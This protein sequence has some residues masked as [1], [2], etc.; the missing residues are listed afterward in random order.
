MSIAS[1]YGWTILSRALSQLAPRQ[2]P[3]TFARAPAPHLAPR[4]A[5]KSVDVVTSTPKVN[6][7][8][9]RSIF[10]V[11]GKEYAEIHPTPQTLSTM[12]YI[13]AKLPLRLPDPV[14]SDTSIFEDS[15]S[16]IC[17][18]EYV[19]VSMRV[20]LRKPP[21]S[22]SQTLL[23]LIRRE[24]YEEA[25]PLCQELLN[26]DIEIPKSN[27]YGYAVLAVLSSKKLSEEEKVRRCEV[28]LNLIPSARDPE[29]GDT[30]FKWLRRGV[31]QFLQPTMTFV[32]EFS[33][34]MASK[35]YAEYICPDAMI[36]ITRF[37]STRVALR[38]VKDILDCDLSYAVDEHPEGGG[39]LQE[40]HEKKRLRRLRELAHRVQRPA[41]ETFARSGK[42]H[43][44]MSL[45]PTPRDPFRLG[46]GTYDLLLSLLRFAPRSY[47]G[48]I[49]RVEKLRM[50]P[51]Y[52]I[53]TPR[54]PSNDRT[55]MPGK[56]ILLEEELDPQS[57]FYMGEALAVQ[58]QS[59]LD[60][61]RISKPSVPELV[62]F[63]S[64]YLESGRT[65]AICRLRHYVLK[66]NWPLGGI[67]LYAEMSYYLDQELY[68]LVLQ[69]FANYFYFSGIPEKEVFAAIS[70]LDKSGHPAYL[71]KPSVTSRRWIPTESHS[72][73][74]WH[75]LARSALPGHG[76]GRLY[77]RFIEYQTGIRDDNIPENAT[78]LSFPPSIQRPL[79]PSLFTVF[80][81]RM[82]NIQ[83][84][85]R[86]TE[87]FRDMVK[88]GINPTI[89]HYTL[90]ATFYL[91]AGDIQRAFSLVD[92][93]EQA[94]PVELQKTIEISLEK[95]HR[96]YPEPG[97]P[98]P[99]V[100]Y[101]TS[102]LGALAEREYLEEGK[103]IRQ[104]FHNRFI[105]TM[106][107]HEPLD[108]GLAYLQRLENKSHATEL[109][110]A[111][112]LAPS[113]V[114]TNDSSQYL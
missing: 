77:D 104:L 93:L 101:Y 71:V 69:T 37:A 60:S 7:R 18:H 79:S 113:R 78:R 51:L 5:S 42:F 89:E 39:S 16:D 62:T 6:S 35:G 40:R 29:A 49:E 82:L 68:L 46:T 86:A 24:K 100:I 91:H 17:K 27:L 36:F 56:R 3:A 13:D 8:T 22:T 110:H 103:R 73:L 45:L 61:M 107:L 111:G 2:A 30:N 63:F 96:L 57:S 88:L 11:D 38:F 4:A 85:G 50:D 106:G 67:F 72:D 12:S 9:D 10:E 34:I 25:W 114:S 53:H 19:A 109:E 102:I 112:P 32:F 14:V 31:F 66:Q 80:I 87:F 20:S 48:Y 59:I 33:L 54:L 47:P 43:E 108:Y 41:I 26:S 28:W 65:T 76:I 95:L 83:Q 105:Y 97:I 58:L 1:G 44:A 84:P 98:T 81:S 15:T 94:H 92:Y 74:A 90:L 64:D 75:A 52:S 55:S 70:S 23:D 99:D 21:S